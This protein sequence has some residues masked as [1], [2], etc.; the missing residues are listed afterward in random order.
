MATSNEATEFE[1]RR[2]RGVPW[3][4]RAPIDGLFRASCYAKTA[5]QTEEPEFKMRASEDEA[6][7]WIGMRT[8]QRGFPYWKLAERGLS[9]AR[10]LKGG[11]VLRAAL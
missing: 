1:T 2:R 11:T 8:R 10:R 3:P 4:G 5:H 6:L 9:A 7:K